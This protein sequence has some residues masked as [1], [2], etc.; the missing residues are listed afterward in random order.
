MT[1]SRAQSKIDALNI[2][3]RRARLQ[4][5]AGTPDMKLKHNDWVIDAQKNNYVV[6]DKKIKE[7]VLKKQLRNETFTRK[8]HEI[9]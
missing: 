6:L 8:L 7:E 9:G 5:K 1:F 3:L 2:K 4:A